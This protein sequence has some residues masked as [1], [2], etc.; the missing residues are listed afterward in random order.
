MESGAVGVL[1]A[2][3]AVAAVLYSSVGHA[4]A[5]GYLASMALLGVAP[6]AMRPVAL[7][8]NVAVATIATFKFYRAGRFDW[9]VLWPFAATSI[10][11]AALGGA[12]TLPSLVYRPI[13]GAALLFAAY[14]LARN[15]TAEESEPTEAVP[16][17]GPALAAGAVIG[18][19]SGLTGVGGGIFLSPLLMLTRWADAKRTAGVSAAFILLNSIAGLAAVAPRVALPAATPIW[20]AV[21]VI[22]GWVGAELGSRRMGSIA[23]RR[24]LAVVLAIAGLK[25]ALT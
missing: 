16:P 23:L 14:R 13:V 25:L 10:P 24:V 17:L 5:S 22:G 3:F 7:V 19:L 1:A 8:L 15:T 21:V 20:I 9:R 6:D 2:M 12:L 11:F 18:L 4:G